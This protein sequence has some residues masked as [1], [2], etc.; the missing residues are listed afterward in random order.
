MQRNGLIFKSL[1]DAGTCRLVLSA[2]GVPEL[3]TLNQLRFTLVTDSALV[4]AAQSYWHPQPDV[5]LPARPSWVLN[6]C[7]CA[8][9][10]AQGLQALDVAYPAEPPIFNHPRAVM[11]ARRDI[12]GLALAGIAGLDVPKCRRFKAQSPR[13]FVDC[14]EKGGFHYPVTVQPTTSRNG[15][16][17]IWIAHPLDWQTAFNMARGGQQHQMVQGHPDEASADWALRMVFVGR[18]GTVEPYRLGTKEGLADAAMQPS[19]PFVQSVFTAAI[20]RIPLD[21]WMLD[22][23]VLAPD[24][25]RLLDVSAGLHVPSEDDNLPELRQLGLRIS[26]HLTSRVSALL[27]EPSKW[28]SDARKLREV[29]ALKQR[30]GA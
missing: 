11:V 20:A 26:T 13:S 1:S 4:R 12:A 30:Y 19:K 3:S 18:G 15:A 9:T 21:F 6:T 27:A 28:R 5:P 8:D 7:A 25:L 2:K 24:R 23:A 14:F 22:A 29:A 16:D 17:R 10:F